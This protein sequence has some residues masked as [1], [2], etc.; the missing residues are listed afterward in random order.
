MKEFTK[1]EA[2]EFLQKL[3][4]FGDDGSGAHFDVESDVEAAKEGRKYGT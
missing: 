2:R 1:D 4:T 3:T